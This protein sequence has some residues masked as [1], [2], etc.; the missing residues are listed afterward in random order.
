M[1]KEVK[2]IPE[3]MMHAVINAGLAICMC[4]MRSSE[5]RDKTEDKDVKAFLEAEMMVLGGALSIFEAAAS[6]KDPADC[7]MAYG[8]RITSILETVQKGND[9]NDGND[10]GS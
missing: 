7:C 5:S 1:R 9:G 6:G 8:E 4:V 10:E 3:E 2:D